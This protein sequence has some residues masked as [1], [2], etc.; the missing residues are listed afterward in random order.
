MRTFDPQSYGAA[1]A[2]LLDPPRL[3]ELGPGQPNGSVH[4]RLA[5]LDDSRLFPDQR[6]VD[7]DMAACCHSGLWLL[8]DFL[9][10]SHTISQR[11]STLAAAARE[12]FEEASESDG[13]SPAADY[14]QSL[15]SWDAFRFVDLCEAALYGHDPSQELCR[16]IAQLEWQLLFDFC[17]RKAIGAS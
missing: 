5:A 13:S 3:C 17:Y 15:S 2:E 6:I 10:E 8:H 12:L 4:D 11:I 9:D 16:R 14:F 7:G 1:C